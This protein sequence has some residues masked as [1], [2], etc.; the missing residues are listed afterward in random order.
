MV[1]SNPAS[2]S[3]V[4][5]RIA[6]TSVRTVLTICMQTLTGGCVAATSCATEVSTCGAIIVFKKPPQT[7][8]CIPT[9][10]PAWK[11][12]QQQKISTIEGE[13]PHMYTP[14]YIYIL[15]QC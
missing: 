10:L 4:A 11:P 15:S 5:A 6:R 8:G 13:G 9:Q 2:T 12:S 3:A 7:I 14:S 1:T